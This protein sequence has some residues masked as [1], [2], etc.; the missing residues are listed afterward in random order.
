MA[1]VVVMAIMTAIA[2]MT[3]IGTVTTI[4][5]DITALQAGIP[6]PALSFGRTE[7]PSGRAARKEMARRRTPA[8]VTS[9]TAVIFRMI[10]AS[11]AALGNWSNC[12]PEPKVKDHYCDDAIEKAQALFFD[13]LYL[14]F[15]RVMRS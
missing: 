3:G 2:T 4:V 5:M 13:P 8:C 7:R 6:G 10:T 11:C 15:R 9:A 12:N 1:M 14:L